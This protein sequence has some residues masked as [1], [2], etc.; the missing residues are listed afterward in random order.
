MRY[1]AE[2]DVSNEDLKQQARKTYEEA[3]EVA[4]EALSVTNP[5][6]LGLALNHTVFLYEI[7]DDHKAACQLAQT[8]LQEGVKNLDDNEP[9]SQREAR[10]ILQLLRDNLSIWSADSGLDE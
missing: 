1:Q 6:R 4:K 10:V 8:T 7:L 3:A 5:V 2:V 9:E